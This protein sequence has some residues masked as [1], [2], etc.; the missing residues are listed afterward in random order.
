VFTIATIP[1]DAQINGGNT[2]Y[3]K[4]STGTHKIRI[5][6]PA[7]IGV[8]WWE[9]ATGEVQYS[10][11]KKLE[12][13]KP[14]RTRKGE[15]VP[16]KAQGG[17]KNFWAFPVW[18]HNTGTLQILSITQGSIQEQFKK[19]EKNEGWGDLTGYDIQIQRE[20]TGQ[21][22]TSYTVT[23]LKPTPLN[24]DIKEQLSIGGLPNMEALFD[25]LDPFQETVEINDL[26]F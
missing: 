2:N 25:G 11:G 14:K 5:L 21:F 17:T 20:G 12:G 9:N 16:A 10:G 18:N 26:P 8:E 13:A 1:D 7:I 23:P 6:A 4:L 22:D 19:L 15:A 3:L 24:D